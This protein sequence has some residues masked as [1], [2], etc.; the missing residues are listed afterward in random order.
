MCGKDEIFRE[1]KKLIDL[2]NQKQNRFTFIKQM[3]CKCKRF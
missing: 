3:Q 2:C 1:K